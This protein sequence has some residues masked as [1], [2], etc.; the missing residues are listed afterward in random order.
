MTKND[1]V[2]LSGPTS[3]PLI[4]PVM[5]PIAMNNAVTG[6]PELRNLPCQGKLCAAYALCQETPAALKGI[7]AALRGLQD[8]IGGYLVDR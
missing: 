4:C 7:A 1:D 2:S 3:P 8:A 6:Q 5:P